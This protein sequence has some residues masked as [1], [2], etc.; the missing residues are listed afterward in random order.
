MGNFHRFSL[1]CLSSSEIYVSNLCLCLTYV[2]QP[3]Y[4]KYTSPQLI[5]LPGV[6]NQI[7]WWPFLASEIVDSA[8]AIWVLGN[9]DDARNCVNENIGF[10]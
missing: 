1:F 8:G 10:L 2:T 7:V 9:S 5:R 4:G 3:K 6:A